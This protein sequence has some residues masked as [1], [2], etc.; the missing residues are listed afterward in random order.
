MSYTS[1]VNNSCNEKLQCITSNTTEVFLYERGEKMAKLSYKS[2]C[3][4]FLLLVSISVL[5]GV[6]FV[7]PYFLPFIFAFWLAKYACPITFYLQ[8]RFHVPRSIGS[9]LTL[10][11]L[12][13]VVGA[14]LMLF[15]DALLKQLNRLLDNLP[16]YKENLLAEVMSVCAYCDRCLKFETGTTSDY[17]MTYITSFMDSN[18]SVFPSFTRQTIALMFQTFQFLAQLG[19][20]IISTLLIVQD[21]EKLRNLYHSWFLHDDIDVILKKLSET[22]VTYIKMQCVIIAVIAVLCTVGLY[23]SHS[24]YPLLLGIIIAIFDALPLFGSGTILVPWAIIKLFSHNI[25]G[26]AILMSTYLLC[27]F[28][29]QFLESKLLGDTLG[30]A[31]IYFVMSLFV[32]IDLFGLIGVILGP[33][34]VLL[35]KTIYQIYKPKA[36]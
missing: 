21:R 5:I 18:S 3:I 2:K 33:F 19:I 14:S 16:I 10:L 6:K 9:I 36:N 31:P 29:R 22:G 4:L 12:L 7:L 32:G 8:K 20:M 26:A 28:T 27:Q 30:L 15:G 35:I 23:L 34:S 24:S 1:V 11:A 13:F 17:V 25:I